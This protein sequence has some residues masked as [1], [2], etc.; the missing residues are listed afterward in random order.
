MHWIQ[1][2]NK[3]MLTGRIHEELSSTLTTEEDADE[4]NEELIQV[5]FT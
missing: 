2:E 1:D 3:G 5:I 4:N